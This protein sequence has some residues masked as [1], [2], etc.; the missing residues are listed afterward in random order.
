MSTIITL[1]ALKILFMPSL[2]KNLAD[3][4]GQGVKDNSGGHAASVYKKKPKEKQKEGS[5]RDKKS[6][7]LKEAYSPTEPLE[8]EVIAGEL[9]RF[10]IGNTQPKTRL[11][12][13]KSRFIAS[14]GVPGFHTFQSIM[15]EGGEP[16][17]YKTLAR[18]L[19]CSLVLAEIDL[20]SD[21]IGN[22]SNGCAVKIDHDS[23]LWPIVIKLM[24]IQNDINKIEFTFEDLDKILYPP[25]YKVSA[26]AGGL[27][28]EIRDRLTASEA[29]QTE[30][31]AQV[32]K[33]LVSPP[34]LIA[35]IQDLNAPADLQLKQE[36]SEFIQGRL[37]LLKK[38]ALKSRGF[39]Q[40]VS[41]LEVSEHKQFLC[42]ELSEFLSENRAYVPTFNIEQSITDSLQEIRTSVDDFNKILS[43]KERLMLNPLNAEHLKY[44]Q[45]KTTFIKG[46]HGI[47]LGGAKVTLEGETYS[48]P[49]KIAQIMK[50]NSN[51][52]S[53]TE[54]K[55]E[56]DKIRKP[57]P[58]SGMYSFF[59]EMRDEITQDKTTRL[60]YK[61]KDIEDLNLKEFDGNPNNSLT[62]PSK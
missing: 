9:Y 19:V 5:Q 28:K 48:I 1:C 32:L 29:F 61:I 12:S 51:R 4:S 17:D 16:K 43:L 27:S 35:M 54:Y 10:W 46:P 8:L 62:S 58:S 38:E 40:F 42:E 57:L 59:E 41:S 22:N 60:F 50:L 34:E 24:S 45:S 20:K 53:Y 25:N 3:F 13:D 31:Y 30:V 7:F 33:L 37:S 47:L 11:V 14:E 26:W 23:S 36:I 56:I 55:D 2:I 6:W 18:I 49:T 21:N 44:W 52:F 39:R 15:A